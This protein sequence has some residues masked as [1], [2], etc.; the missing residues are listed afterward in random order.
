MA[1]LND[2]LK[3]EV[4][5]SAAVYVASH[6]QARLRS[7]HSALGTG[8]IIPTRHERRAAG[9]ENQGSPKFSVTS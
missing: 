2:W 6:P 1:K 9:K 4:V 3:A 8:P 5:L 7:M